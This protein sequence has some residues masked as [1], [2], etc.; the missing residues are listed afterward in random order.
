MFSSVDG[1]P[2]AVSCGV[3]L[4]AG[5]GIRL[6][7]LENGT[8]KPATEILGVSLGDRA[9][10]ACMGAGVS[11]FVIVLGAQAEA[12]RAHFERV[13]ARRGVVVEFVTAADWQ[14]GN[15]VSALAARDRIEG[16]RF[17]LVMADHLVSSSLI[18]RVLRGPLG[19]QDV[20]LGVDRDTARLF[21]LDDAMKVF[22]DEGRIRRIGKQLRTWN[23]VDTGVFLATPALFDALED[24]EQRG[25]YGLCD[26]IESLA[27]DGQVQAIDVT[28]EPWI[29]VDTP[30]A[31]REAR[32]R[33]LQS[34][35]KPGADG[36]VAAH[37]NR[38]LSVPISARLAR[39]R[40]TPTQITV[41][42]FLIA[43]V[44]AGL[45]RGR[46]PLDGGDRRAPRAALLGG[47]RMRRGARPP[48]PSSDRS[49]G[50]ARHHA[51]SL[52]RCRG[53]GLSRSVRQRAF[54]RRSAC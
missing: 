22:V 51:R 43:L 52:R 17:L 29:D 30:E 25:R 37:L 18:Q 53:G 4:A 26:G 31:L 28:G 34:L 44:G 40:I 50:V 49:G 33:L 9:M 54:S 47:R 11:H 15:G 14:L 19:P 36:Y 46:S 3:I 42:S 48:S 24:A 8:P 39:T 16:V 2:G 1:R 21:D 35:G 7:A 23:A 12:V 13:A 10:L 41:I 45:L 38:R 5:E 6:S 20:G 27:D 32:R